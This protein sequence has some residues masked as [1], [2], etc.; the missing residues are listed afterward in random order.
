MAYPTQFSDQDLINV[1][2]ENN[3]SVAE[4]ARVLGVSRN[5]I[6][7]RIAASEE[8]KEAVEGIRREVIGALETRMA[9]LAIQENSLE[10]S[11][12]ASKFLLKTIGRN[13]GYGGKF[14]SF[15]E[16][17]AEAAKKQDKEDLLEELL[18]D[19]RRRALEGDLEAAKILLQTLTTPT[20]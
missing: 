5:A 15:E 9:A 11:F 2:K 3:S 17:K 18:Q 19:L 14:S 13:H 7:K 4:A 1:L 12:K 8:L 6:Y 20:P 16:Y 10:L